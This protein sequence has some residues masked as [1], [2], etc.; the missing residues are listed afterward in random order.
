MMLYLNGMLCGTSP[1]RVQL[2]PGTYRYKMLTITTKQQR[3]GEIV[4]RARR[5]HVL[6]GE[7]ALDVKGKKQ[8]HL[9]LAQINQ[10]VEHRKSAFQSCAI[11]Q[12]N[13][14]QVVLSLQINPEGRPQNVKWRQ[15]TPAQPRFRKCILRA[16]QRLRFP[17]KPMPTS[18][19]EYTISLN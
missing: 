11:F 17:P 12:P 3:E 4:L 5:S 14:N 10:I 8:A 15:P 1:L 13:T 16:A 6:I 19:E 7:E 2:K 18:L 9:S